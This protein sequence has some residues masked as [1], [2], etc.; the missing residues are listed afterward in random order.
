METKTSSHLLKGV[1]ISLLAIVADLLLSKLNPATT[2]GN[3]YLAR[4]IVAFAGVFISSF[5]YV[6]QTG[7]STLGEIFAHGFR[8]TALV[9]FLLAVYTYVAIKFIYP[10]PSAAEMD[11]AVKAIE[12]QGVALGQ[13]ARRVAE[14][15][16][17]N[18]LSIH[19]FLFFRY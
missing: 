3:R 15:S 13:E 9:A 14:K 7:A 18:R 6:R 12:Q 11:A 17:A 10:P 19:L 5:I 8:I 16:A 4:M 2:D 1:L